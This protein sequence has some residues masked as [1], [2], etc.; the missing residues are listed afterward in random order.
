[1]LFEIPENTA[2]KK[3]KAE[4]AETLEFEREL[5]AAERVEA[6]KEASKQGHILCSEGHSITFLPSAQSPAQECDA[7][8]CPL[9]AQDTTAS[10]TLCNWFG[11]HSCAKIQG[12]IAV[13]NFIEAKSVPSE[14]GASLERPG[15]ASAGLDQRGWSCRRC[16]FFNHEQG[17][18]AMCRAPNTDPT[19][20]IGSGEDTEQYDEEDNQE[21]ARENGV[22]RGEERSLGPLASQ[23][24]FPMDVR[25]T[26]LTGGEPFGVPTIKR[27]ER[28]QQAEPL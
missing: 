22:S 3:A 5:T 12:A 2:L 7:C 17:L 18:C 26:Q 28:E 16:T 10:C 4:E 27:T 6:A 23:Q 19:D 1:M 21:A 15:A 14:Y 24:E 8:S 13:A 11:C 9:D 20:G 25:A